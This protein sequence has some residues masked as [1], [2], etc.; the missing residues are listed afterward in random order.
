MK[1][2]N[3]GGVPIIGQAPPDM[4]EVRTYRRVAIMLRG[5]GDGNSDAIAMM[6]IVV[7]ELGREI[8]VPMNARS[9]QQIGRAMFDAV[10]QLQTS[11]GQGKAST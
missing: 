6:A 8:Q 4:P 9:L 10:D 2:P 1:R 7:P 5:G 11:D 3:G